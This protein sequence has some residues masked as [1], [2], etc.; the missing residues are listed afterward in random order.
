MD[1]EALWGVGGKKGG[2]KEYFDKKIN[3]IKTN[4]CYKR[5]IPFF[6]KTLTLSYKWKVVHFKTKIKTNSTLSIKPT[7]FFLAPVSNNLT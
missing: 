6:I 5:L 2:F 7:F 1:Q 3:Y 4:I